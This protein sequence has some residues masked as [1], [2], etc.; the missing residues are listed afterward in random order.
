MSIL[1]LTG[2]QKSVVQSNN[3]KYQRDIQLYSFSM[4]QIYGHFYI[5]TIVDLS[6]F[7]IVKGLLSEWYHLN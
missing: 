7:G 5:H 1:N 4:N 3:A 2:L 6:E